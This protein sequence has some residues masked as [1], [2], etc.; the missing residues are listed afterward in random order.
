MN[1]LITGGAGF[2]ASHIVDKY[3]SLDHKVI[4]ID[5]N[6]K[7]KS[8]LNQKAQYIEADI[9]DAKIENIFKTNQIDVINHHAAQISVESAEKFPEE[10]AKTNIFGTLHLLEM[11]RKY[12]VKKFIFSSSAAVYGNVKQL[13]VTENTPTNPDSQYGLS[14]LCAE[15]YVLL[16]NQ[17]YNLDITVFRYA[18]AYGHR[19]KGGAIPIF[20]R[21]ILQ[22]KPLTLRGNGETT[23]DFV[24]VEDIAEIN[25]LVLTKKTKSKIFNVSTN[26][27]ISINKFIAFLSAMTKMQP[28]IIKTPLIA[29]EIINSRLDNSLLFKEL[30]WKPKTS[31]QEGLQK[32]II[33]LKKELGELK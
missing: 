15:K 27:E 8:Y 3:I 20:T 26:T 9:N 25:A 19:Q 11:A 4:V 33:A 13:P 14:K 22:N 7:N 23:R 29:G 2:I 16:Y 1:I 5:H 17:L 10:N 18:N 6:L 21:N 12:K 32:T 30:Q 31:F 24:F 28:Q